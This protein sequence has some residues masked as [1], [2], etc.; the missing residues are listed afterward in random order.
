[1]GKQKVFEA[2]DGL[3][4]FLLNIDSIAKHPYSNGVNVIKLITDLQDYS[5]DLRKMVEDINEVT[6]DKIQPDK[7]D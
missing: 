2:L 5:K 3:D 4:G 7:I 6:E 1:M